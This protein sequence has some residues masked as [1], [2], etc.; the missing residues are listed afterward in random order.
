MRGF[1]DVRNVVATVPG[2]LKSTQSAVRQPVIGM[3]EH[4]AELI[5]V[6]ERQANPPVMKS[7]EARRTHRRD[8]PLRP[9]I[10]A[11]RFSSYG[12]TVALLFGEAQTKTDLTR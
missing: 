7:I 12:L 5:P 2:I 1:G 11:Q 3:D 9:A 8:R 4:A 10:R 6:R